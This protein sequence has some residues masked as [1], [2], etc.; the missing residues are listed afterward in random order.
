M[1]NQAVDED[2]RAMLLRKAK[3]AQKEEKADAA[4]KGSMITGDKAVEASSDLQKKFHIDAKRKK[5]NE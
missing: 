1:A 5:R 2:V 4:L 3:Q